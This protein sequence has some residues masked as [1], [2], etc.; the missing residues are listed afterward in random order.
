MDRRAGVPTAFFPELDAAWELAIAPWRIERG[1]VAILFSGGVDSS[2]I[3]WE[4]RSRPQLTLVTV[5]TA[6]S[7]DLRAAGEAA[8]AL[9]LPWS[10]TVVTDSEIHRTASE[11]ADET[12]TSSATGRSVRV[13]LALAVRHAPAPSVLCGQGADELFLG[14]AHFRH[15]SAADARAR[16][17]LDLQ[18]LLEDDW[19][20]SVRVAHRFG[21]DVNAPYLHP[22]FIEAAGRIPVE[23][24]MPTPTPKA[25]FRAWAHRRGLPSAVAE[26]PKRALQYGSGVDRVL[27]RATG[28]TPR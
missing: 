26:R 8:E 15:Q 3:A 25:L 6:G 13:A 20:S 23:A 4:L 22:S 9:G 27:R 18:R 17:A 2:L 14:Y 10:P 28:P 1:P 7:P 24:R 21:R 5:G 12:R 11:L 16:A 19:P